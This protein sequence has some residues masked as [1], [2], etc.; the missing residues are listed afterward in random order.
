MSQRA[1]FEVKASE[2]LQTTGNAL[3]GRA[4]SKRLWLLFL[5]AI[6]LTLWL[7]KGS[8]TAEGLFQSPQSP[9]AESQAVEQ[10]A[11]AEQPPAEPPAAQPPP[12]EQAPAAEEPPTQQPTSPEQPSTQE[13]PLESP[14][15]PTPS[16]EAAE[17]APTPN[18]ASSGEASPA[19]Q[20]TPEEASRP[21]RSRE[22]EA[23]LTGDPADENSVRNFILDRAEFV[24]TIVVSGAYLW[25]CC[26]V[27]LFLLVPIFMVVLYIRGRSK[28]VAEEEY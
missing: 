7:G 8:V 22:E 10:P 11:P 1:L 26:G 9:P 2:H 6:L 4:G 27:G 23:T 17:P 3:S 19:G 28:V 12:A 24:D 21:P 18:E 13:S 14:I 25:L 20:E 16:P 5:A 15:Q